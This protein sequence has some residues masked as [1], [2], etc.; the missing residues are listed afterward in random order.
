MGPAGT[1]AVRI[2]PGINPDALWLVARTLDGDREAL[3]D[4]RG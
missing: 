2:P 3:I 4:L 1:V